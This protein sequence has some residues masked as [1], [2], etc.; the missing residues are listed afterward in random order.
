MSEPYA[1]VSKKGEQRLSAG[2]PWIYRS[3][4]MDADAEP[5]DTVSVLSQRRQV[6][7]QAL[8]SDQ[9]QITLRMLTRG[10]TVADR[11]LWRARLDAAV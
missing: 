11:A 1:V 10:Q 9:S 7:G 8:F 3:D 5:G 6:L 4:I 2:H